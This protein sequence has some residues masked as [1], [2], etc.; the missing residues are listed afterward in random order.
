MSWQAARALHGGFVNGDAGG[1]GERDG[2]IGL[3]RGRTTKR[4]IF[5]RMQAVGEVE[6][7][8]CGIMAPA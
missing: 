3:L 7:P 6:W 5:V 8:V 1:L 2:A 4:R